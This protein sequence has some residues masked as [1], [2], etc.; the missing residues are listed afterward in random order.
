VN[1]K[2]AKK[3]FGIWASGRFNTTRSGPKFF[4]L[5]FSKTVTAFLLPSFVCDA[6]TF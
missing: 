4:W 5:L 3:T 1:K 2:E 6:D